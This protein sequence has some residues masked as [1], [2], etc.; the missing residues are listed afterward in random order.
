MTAA[1]VKKLL[2]GKIAGDEE[3]F[4]NGK[5]TANQ[6][7]IRKIAFNEILKAMGEKPVTK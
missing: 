3:A 1:E 2:R 7:H 5:L 6:K 4:R